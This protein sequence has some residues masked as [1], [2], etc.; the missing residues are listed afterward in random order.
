MIRKEQIRLCMDINMGLGPLHGQTH[1][2]GHGHIIKM[3][4][5]KDMEVDNQDGSE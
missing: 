4:T 3:G 5:D 2:Y 1:G